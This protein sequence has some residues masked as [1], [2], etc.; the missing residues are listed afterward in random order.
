MIKS[1]EH[2]E[3]TVDITNAM[4][5]LK[6]TSRIISIQAEKIKEGCN[7]CNENDNY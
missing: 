3:C 5:I 1:Y 6:S 4:G 2:D 7:K